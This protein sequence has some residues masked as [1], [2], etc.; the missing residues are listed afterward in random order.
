MPTIEA[1]RST[2]GLRF[3]LVVSKY[4]D[5]VTDRLQNGALQVETSIANLSTEPMPIAIAPG[6]V[7]N[8][9]RSVGYYVWREGRKHQNVSA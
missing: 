6:I 2:A 4:H 9:I 7:L 1:T 8:G 3:A 5:F